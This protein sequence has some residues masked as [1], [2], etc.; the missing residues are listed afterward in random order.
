MTPL[1]ANE[2]SKYGLANVT[3]RAGLSLRAAAVRADACRHARRAAA[4]G[5]GL[6]SFFRVEPDLLTAHYEIAYDVTEART[7]RLTF[8]L[9]GKHAGRVGDPRAR[10]RD[11]QGIEQRSEGQRSGS[12]PC[13]SAN[14][15]A[16]P[17]R[18]AVD[19]QQPLG[20]AR[21]S[22]RKRATAKD[23]DKPPSSRRPSDAA[24]GAGDC[25]WPIKRAWWPSREARRATCK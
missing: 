24:A 22:R 13:C 7:S 12:G 25:T 8:A 14:R 6:F 5:S 9:A 18:L 23:S 4:H 16:A 10:R 1:D 3:T 21:K 17:I 15:G 19:F 11:D 20:D 2:K